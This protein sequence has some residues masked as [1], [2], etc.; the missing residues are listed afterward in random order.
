M[1]EIDLTTLTN[2]QLRNLEYEQQLVVNRLQRLIYELGA[3]D[4]SEQRKLL[5]AQ[6]YLFRLRQQIV[7]N[8]EKP[9]I[10]PAAAPAESPAQAKGVVYRGGGTHYGG[11]RRLLPRP[12][13][14][15]NGAWRRLAWK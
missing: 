2:E 4:E 11:Q 8:T 7:G 6:G 3:G 13:P 15:L 5:D 1:A 10:E 14:A 12:R 9:A